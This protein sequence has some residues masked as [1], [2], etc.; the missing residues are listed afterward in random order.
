MSAFVIAIFVLPVLFER[1]C[2]L[3]RLGPSAAISRRL[4]VYALGL[5]ASLT[6]VS[7]LT[8]SLKTDHLVRT[9]LA[10]SV[11][12]PVAVFYCMLIAVCIWLRRTGRSQLGW[13]IAILPNPML[14]GAVAVLARLIV[15]QRTILMATI[16]AALLTSLWIGLISLWVWNTRNAPLDAPDA[17]FAV[18][19]ATLV[20]TGAIVFLPLASPLFLD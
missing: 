2:F 16:C 6:L 17:K 18:G 13:W 12:A 9:V 8:L 15:P 3:L 14:A 19:F 4:R 10:P 20:N 1:D 11:T 7:L 5:L